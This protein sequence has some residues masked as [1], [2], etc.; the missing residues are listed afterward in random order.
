[1]MRGDLP[2]TL[3]EHV[4]QAGPEAGGIGPVIFI[5]TVRIEARR[6]RGLGVALRIGEDAMV[7]AVGVRGHLDQPRGLHFPDVLPGDES[8]ARYLLAVVIDH[9]VG[10]DVTATDRP[11]RSRLGTGRA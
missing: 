1:M 3:A 5:A 4:L 7:Q 2:E 11:G 6:R 10:R 8:A 9:R